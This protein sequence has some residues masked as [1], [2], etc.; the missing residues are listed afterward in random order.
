MGG[1]G[2]EKLLERASLYPRV[3]LPLAPRENRSFITVWGVPESSCIFQ[4]PRIQ[5]KSQGW[6]KPLFTE[7]WEP[8]TLCTWVISL[9]PDNSGSLKGERLG[10]A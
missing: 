4:G 8:D 9:H 6:R 3:I 5:M 10:Q 1:R 7:P 2:V